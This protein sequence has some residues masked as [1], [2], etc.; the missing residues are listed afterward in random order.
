MCKTLHETPPQAHRLGK[1]RV[2][3]ARIALPVGNGGGLCTHILPRLA[4]C[5]ELACASVVLCVGSSRHI[6]SHGGQNTS[7]PKRTSRVRRTAEKYSVASHAV[8]MRSDV[9]VGAVSGGRKRMVGWINVC[10]RHRHGPGPVTMDRPDD[11]TRDVALQG[12]DTP[13]QDCALTCGRG[14][15]VSPEKVSL[16]QPPRC[17]EQ[18]ASAGCA[19]SMCPL[20]LTE[21]ENEDPRL[22]SIHWRSDV[23][24]GCA[25]RVET[26]G[27][28]R[29]RVPGW[30]FVTLTQEPPLL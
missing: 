29:T 19:P 17:S 25:R 24:V 22:Q 3:L 5:H 18:A 27:S 8:Q 9:N 1:G 2:A 10:D 6:I 30:Q 21:V 11:S 15:S 16:R 23:N 4:I 13:T 12:A 14:R 20:L 28:E 7:P 26:P